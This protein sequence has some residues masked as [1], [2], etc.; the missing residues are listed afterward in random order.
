MINLKKENT[1][2]AYANSELIELATRLQK[3]L[4]DNNA[5]Y[6]PEYET[7]DGYIYSIR[8]TGSEIDIHCKGQVNEETADEVSQ[9]DNGKK[10]CSKT[11]DN[12]RWCSIVEC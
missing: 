9:L 3:L 6:N 4:K 7:H 1:R 10:H 5:E 2:L 8:I 12:I 11:V